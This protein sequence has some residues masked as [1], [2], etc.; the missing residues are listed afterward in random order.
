MLSGQQTVAKPFAL[1]TEMHRQV[2]LQNS[3]SVQSPPIIDV[4]ITV[5]TGK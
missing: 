4:E 3:N 1:Q 5:A 2:A